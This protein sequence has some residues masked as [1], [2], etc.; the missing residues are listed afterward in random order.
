M[1]AVA[2]RVLLLTVAAP[3]ACSV[4]LAD[5]HLKGGVLLVAARQKTSHETGN[6]DPD[7]LDDVA[8]RRGIEELAIAKTASVQAADSAKDASSAHEDLLAQQAVSQSRTSYLKV[9]PLTPEAN[10]QL[11]AVRR[12]EEVAELHAKHAEEVLF[13]SRRVPQAAAEKAIEA[14]KGWMKQ[15]A[16]KTAEH[17]AAH[18]D[19]RQEKL[20]GA[21]A[22]A[23][24]PYHL[25]LL[26][27][28]KF[29][30]ET[31]AK[32]KSAQSSSVKLLDDAKKVASKAQ[33]LQAAGLGV[34]AR[35]TLSTA[36][37]M[38]NEA[39]SLRQWSTKLYNQANTACGSTGSYEM[40]EQQ[41]AANVAVTSVMNAP[42]QLPPP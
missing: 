7:T 37:G 39:E 18:S 8:V 15:D 20:A 26:R 28:Q 31:Y 14:V 5:R 33:E 35:Q 4:S 9:K 1:S 42:A 21:V 12:A 34:E 32:A 38:S 17:S 13:E 16:A 10:A 24:E 3:V 41:A 27:N 36:A 22:A 11:L 40:L 2:L 29:C 19:H 30:Q 6:N 25:A 23:A